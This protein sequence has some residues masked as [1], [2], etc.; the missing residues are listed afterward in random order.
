MEAGRSGLH[1]KHRHAGAGRFRR[2]MGFALWGAAGFY[3]WDFVGHC[4]LPGDAIDTESVGAADFFCNGKSG[5]AF[6][7]CCSQYRI[8][9][10]AE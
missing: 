10:Q 2:G 3:L 7:I 1:A 8:H 6:E 4:H 9:E 5:D